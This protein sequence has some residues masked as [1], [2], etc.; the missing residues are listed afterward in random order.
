[1]PGYVGRKF[2]LQGDLD[3][4]HTGEAILEITVTY[5]RKCFEGTPALEHL[6]EVAKKYTS[7]VFEGTDINF[8]PEVADSDATSDSKKKET[9]AEASN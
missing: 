5:L 4:T 9:K 8:D 6:R 7:F 2:A 1:M 3:P